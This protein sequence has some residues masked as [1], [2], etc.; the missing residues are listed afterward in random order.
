MSRNF[1]ID[2]KG[3]HRAEAGGML[4]GPTCSL[5]GM[6]HVGGDCVKEVVYDAEG[7]PVYAEF[8]DVKPRSSEGKAAPTLEEAADAAFAD[9]L[10]VPADTG[11][12]GGAGLRRAVAARLAELPEDKRGEVI[13]K[14]LRRRADEEA[15]GVALI[16]KAVRPL[17]VGKP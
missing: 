6:P 7:V 8:F 13:L 12:S 5:C 3:L 10:D 9:L 14:T 2:L 16:S 11:V 17:P 15:A 4:Y 1:A